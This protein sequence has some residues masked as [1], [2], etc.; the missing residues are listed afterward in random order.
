MQPDIYIVDDPIYEARLL[1]A[2]GASFSVTTS[3]ARRDRRIFLDSFDGR[4]HRA[5]LAC[6]HVAGSCRLEPL[7][8][9]RALAV[10]ACDE[11]QPPRTPRDVP[12]GRLRDLLVRR[13]GLRALMPVVVLRTDTRVIRL[14]GHDHC[15]A[16]RLVVTTW[17]L[18]KRRPVTV[19]RTLAVHPCRGRTNALA[20]VRRAAAAAGLRPLP[21]SPLAWALAANGLV[22]R[23]YTSKIDV[24]LAN[25]LTAREAAQAI[26]R[27][28]LQTM[29]QNEGGLR[30]DLDTEFL[31]DFRVAVRRTR[32]AL[33]ELPE[34]FP[35]RVTE[36]FKTGFRELGRL[37]GPVR[38]LDVYLLAEDEIRARVPANLRPGLDPLFTTLRAERD[39]AQREIVAALASPSYKR[40]MRRWAAV[41]DPPAGR[42]VADSPTAGLPVRDLARERIHRRW[43]RLI[44]RGLAITDDATAADLHALRIHGKKLR[45][46]L[47]FFASLFPAREIGALVRRLKGLQDNLGEHNDLVVQREH[48]RSEL[49][50]VAGLE[51]AAAIEALLDVLSVRQRQVRREFAGAFG[52][53]AGAE[54]SAHFEQ[55]FGPRP[56]PPLSPP[57]Q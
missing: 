27:R 40:L 4:L 6:M 16:A 45:Y 30:A 41:L 44:E 36:E 2:L 11:A 28:L 42:P 43:R 3:A 29:R 47:E 50:A 31:H 7:E 5:G 54:V 53:F 26:C 46:L 52:D 51:E 57:G 10:A 39:D 21:Q 25:D 35:E 55:L 49:A 14:R 56:A 13:L 22:P 48:L 17:R 32:A 37:T 9:G 12:A 24:V 1:A 33:G 23:S 19:L 8:G 20:R 18:E 34:V 38:D 15:V